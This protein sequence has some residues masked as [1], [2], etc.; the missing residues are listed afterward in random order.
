MSL[1]VNLL[2]LINKEPVNIAFFIIIAISIIDGIIM[3]SY[4]RAHSSAIGSIRAWLY[5]VLIILLSSLIAFS[6]DIRHTVHI[7]KY[8]DNEAYFFTVVFTGC[9]IVA[10]T[11][12]YWVSF[13][14]LK[15]INKRS[16]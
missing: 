12:S 3:A 6:I 14:V 9:A 13:F 1:S 5:S 2:I 7:I 4:N 16:Q 11:F 15:I 8:H 10:V